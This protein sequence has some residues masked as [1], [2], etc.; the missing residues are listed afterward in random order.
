MVALVSTTTTVAPASAPVPSNSPLLLASS[1]VTVSS[2]AEVMRGAATKVSSVLPVK[3]LV[4]EALPPVSTMRTAKSK[5]SP[6][7]GPLLAWL[8]KLAGKT[9][10]SKVSG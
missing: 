1:A 7:A 10:D 3:P 8:T 9:N 2:D 6:A 5:L 4:A